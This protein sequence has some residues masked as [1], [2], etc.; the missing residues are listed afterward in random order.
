MGV[1]FVP[2][3]EKGGAERER[4]APDFVLAS[5]VP[6]RKADVLVLNCLDV[7]ADGWNSRYDLSQLIKSFN[8]LL[9]SFIQHTHALATR[10][11]VSF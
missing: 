7:E 5:Y 10:C 6:D 4:E 8:T 11:R 3:Q 1:L 2:T 9:L